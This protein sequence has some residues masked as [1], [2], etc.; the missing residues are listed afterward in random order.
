MLSRLRQGYL[1]E[2]DINKLNSRKINFTGANTQE[3]LQELCKYLDKLPPDTVCILSTRFLCKTLNEEM[4]LRISSDEIKLVAE[5]VY[6]GPRNLEN[7]V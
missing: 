7:K 6:D 3:N 2:D 5:D 4:L 1:T